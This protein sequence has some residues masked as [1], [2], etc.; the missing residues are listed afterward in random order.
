MLRIGWFTRSISAWYA[1]YVVN[2]CTTPQIMC[3]AGHA[4]GKMR[5]STVW[6]ISSMRSPTPRE[7]KSSSRKVVGIFSP[8]A[9]RNLRKARPWNS[10]S[11]IH[12]HMKGASSGSAMVAFVFIKAFV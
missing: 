8:Y 6:P 1:V 2:S 4:S 3:T 5:D 11:Y 12:T 10:S 7:L 9:S